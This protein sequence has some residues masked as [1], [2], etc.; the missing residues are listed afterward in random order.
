[1]RYS[2]SRPAFWARFLFLFLA[3][4]SLSGFSYSDRKR[5]GQEIGSEIKAELQRIVEKTPSAKLRKQWRAERG[6]ASDAL[7]SALCIE[8]DRYSPEKWDEAVALF[9]KA[10][11]YASNRSYRKA[12]YLAKKPGNTQRMPIDLLKR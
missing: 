12:I 10:K 5:L 9:Q 7:D 3:I 11:Y 6:N 8:A 2:E 4:T 1:M